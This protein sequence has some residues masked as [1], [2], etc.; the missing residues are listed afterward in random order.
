MR[1]TKTVEV[2][3][4]SR[5]DDG[6]RA[7]RVGLAAVT[8]AAL[9]FAACS[10]SAQRDAERKADEAKKQAGE[11]VEKARDAAGDAAKDATQAAKDAAA[12]VKESAKDAAAKY[13]PVA[14][15][16]ALKGAAAAAE[17]GSAAAVTAGQATES[18]AIRAA[19]LLRTGAIRA[20]LLRE[21]SLDVSDVDIDT[22]ESGK[23]VLI[24]GRVKSEAQRRAVERIA[25]ERAAGYTIENR[26][27]VKG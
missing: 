12:T 25:H 18:A 6:P 2:V 26:L 19:G 4:R 16:A 21:S 24:K 14:K 5:R 20:A 17:L 11:A 3:D 7:R 1:V 13:G 9:L 23:R 22:N 15:D 8:L 27:V 10:T